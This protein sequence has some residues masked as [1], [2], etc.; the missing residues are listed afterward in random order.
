M[1][2]PER[3]FDHLS[4]DPIDVLAGGLLRSDL[5]RRYIDY[6][7]RLPT[8]QY[9]TPEVLA[10]IPDYRLIHKGEVRSL[11]YLVGEALADHLHLHVASRRWS[12]SDCAECV[13]AD[14]TGIR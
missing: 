9:Q 12:S 14:A 13:A 10:A 8:M 5:I 4:E 7:D 6:A 11:G 1:K 2:P 3:V